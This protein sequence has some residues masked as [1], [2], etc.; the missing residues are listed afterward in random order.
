[1]AWGSEDTV[2]IIS[3][4]LG[5]IWTFMVQVINRAVLGP[6][7]PRIHYT[8]MAFWL[9]LIGGGVILTMG[10]IAVANDSKIG[11]GGIILGSAHCLAAL[12]IFSFAL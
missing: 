3:I 11:I 12:I 9:H 8:I 10:I 5:T 1:M 7:T 4:I 2:G 6:G